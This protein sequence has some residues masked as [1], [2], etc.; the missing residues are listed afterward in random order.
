M[1]IWALFKPKYF[2]EKAAE[3]SPSWA[4][5]AELFV[6]ML[7]VNSV[8]DALEDLAVIYCIG[9]AQPAG[10]KLDTYH[11]IVGRYGKGGLCGPSCGVTACF[12]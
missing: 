9:L 6:R 4:D 1:Y 10:T 11:E 12:S 2:P 3:R 5:L 7:L 8:C